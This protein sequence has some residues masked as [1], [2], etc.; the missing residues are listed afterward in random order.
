MSM[1]NC[2]DT[3]G[4]RTREAVSVVKIHSYCLNESAAASTAA[5]DMGRE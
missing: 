3:I 5:V 1:K 4:N 2:N